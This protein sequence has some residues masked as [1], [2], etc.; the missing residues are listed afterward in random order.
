MSNLGIAHLPVRK[1]DIVL[2]GLQSR[3]RPARHQPVPNRHPRAFEGV[4]SRVAPLAPAVE[5]AQHN[6]TRAKEGAHNVRPRTNDTISIRET[7]PIR[8]AFPREPTRSS[9]RAADR[10]AA[11]GG[12]K[13][14]DGAEHRLGDPIHD[15]L[16]TSE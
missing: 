3:V 5:D 1:S 2:A 6:R 11:G 16:N 7:A 10:T 8:L 12:E 9:R 14:I 15:L 13:P 4:I